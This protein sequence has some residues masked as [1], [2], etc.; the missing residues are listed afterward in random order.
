L[1]EFGEALGIAFQMQDDLLGL[2]G[3]PLQF[4]KPIGSDLR[5]RKKSLPILHGLANSP[6]FYALLT[7]T[8]VFDDAAVAEGLALL[9]A[10]ASQEYTQAR[11]RAYHKMALEALEHAQSKGDAHTALLELAAKLLNRTM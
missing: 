1:R 4:G 8:E 3:D 2:W 5:N 6:D 10:A 11:A 9:E 7:E